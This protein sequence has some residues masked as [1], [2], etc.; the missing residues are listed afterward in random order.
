[1]TYE[2]ALA[3]TRDDEGPGAPLTD[4]ELVAPMRDATF[5]S[6]CGAPASMKVTVRIAVRDG[7]AY[8]VSIYANPPDPD[9][10]RCIAQ[11][12]RKLV[13]ASTPHRDFFTTTY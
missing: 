11:A 4:A 1:M 8:G 6:R 2:A 7:R 3:S 12:V 9:V 13:W 5:V 10:A